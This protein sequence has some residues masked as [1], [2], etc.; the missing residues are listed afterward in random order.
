VE[1]PARFVLVGSGNPE[2][3]ELRPQL[4]DRFGLHVEVVTAN[5]LDE[6]VK[7]VIAREAFERDPVDFCARFESE[8]ESLRR[9]LARAR[10]RLHEVESPR[11]LLRRIAELCMRLKVDGHRGELTITRASRALAALEGRR[12]ATAA[13]VRRVAMMS[14]RHRLR[15]DPLE[16][17]T[18]GA[19][20]ER[21]LENLFPP[22]ETDDK[23]RRAKD[24]PDHEDIPPPDLAGGGGRNS[25]GTNESNKGTRG[26]S[27]RSEPAQSSHEQSAASALDARLPEDALD[28]TPR[29]QAHSHT[30]IQ[31]AR[32][33]RNPRRSIYNTERGRYARALSTS[34]GANRI[35][36]DATLRAAS[37]RCAGDRGWGLGVRDKLKARTRA[38]GFA[39]TPPAPNPSP[40]LICAS[41]D[42][43]A[44]WARFL[45]LLL[46]LPVAWL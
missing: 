11:E 31:S 21:A 4:L 6:R 33:Q 46:M 37:L 2:E 16:Q 41:K 32:Y 15:R 12:E 35:A 42:S 25:S 7:I 10:K 22:N 17:T 1:H 18:G 19:E 14:L 8:Q 13:D 30:L 5:D 43:S 26:G 24:R 27:A 40:P 9:K 3:G 36:L 28:E 39:P 45:S 20:I 44:R 34:S 29:A 38:D 23:Q